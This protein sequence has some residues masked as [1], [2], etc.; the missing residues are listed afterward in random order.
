M[1]FYLLA[2]YLFDETEKI[3]ESLIRIIRLHQ[4]KKRGNFDKLTCNLNVCM[5]YWRFAQGIIHGNFCDSKHQK[6]LF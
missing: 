2:I 3:S 5:F 6:Q 1:I 4:S